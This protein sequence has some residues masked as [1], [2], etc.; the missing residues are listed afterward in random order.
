MKKI[1][2]IMLT[3]SIILGLTIINSVEA[4]EGEVCKQETHW[5]YFSLADHADLATRE[6]KAVD[7]TYSTTFDDSK[8]PEDAKIES[9]TTYKGFTKDD[10]AMSY[11]LYVVSRIPVYI[12]N[13]G[14]FHHVHDFL[15]NNHDTNT[16][17][18]NNVD[19]ATRA[20]YDMLTTDEQRTQFRN[21]YIEKVYNAQIVPTEAEV[22]I[23]QGADGVV[24]GEIHRVYGGMSLSS[25]IPYQY[26]VDPANPDVTN[27]VLLISAK[28]K[29]VLSYD[30]KVP[31]E[32]VEPEEPVGP[33]EPLVEEPNPNTGD[34]GVVLSSVM[35]LG[36]SGTGL[37]AYRKR[38]NIK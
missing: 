35:A 3:I 38:K 33:E 1:Y 26:V 7:T 6:G 4:A 25:V 22:T 5:Y 30:C 15:Y 29:V 27:E 16:S 20:N 34:L 9:V 28:T 23:T 11:D 10:I 18:T 21:S 32:P 12:D 13:N 17:S 19:E 37:Y 24:N 8:W 14:E 36:A 31:E 2:S